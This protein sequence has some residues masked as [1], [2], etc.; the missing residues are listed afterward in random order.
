MRGR[1]RHGWMVAFIATPPAGQEQRTT[2]ITH[3]RAIEEMMY[4]YSPPVLDLSFP[5]APAPPPPPPI[6]L[7]LVLE[8]E[9]DDANHDYLVSSSYLL[10]ASLFPS[11]IHSAYVPLDLFT[12][13]ARIALYIYHSRRRVSSPDKFKCRFPPTFDRDI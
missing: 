10:L 11:F 8:G 3:N 5:A 12:K 1:R 7:P 13:G 4:A 9:A 6:P 2:S